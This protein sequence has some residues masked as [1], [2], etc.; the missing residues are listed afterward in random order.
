MKNITSTLRGLGSTTV[1]GSDREQHDFYAT[2][3][4]AVELLLDEEQFQVDILEP[5]CGLN[6]ITDVLKKQR[7]SSQNLR[8]H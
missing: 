5:C 2:E 4:K 7:V 3:P 6:H 1:V 8:P